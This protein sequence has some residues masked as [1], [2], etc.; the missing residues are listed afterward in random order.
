MNI[1]VLNDF[2]AGRAPNPV[3]FTV[4]QFHKM[5]D[6]GILVDGQPVELIDGVVMRKNR[7]AAGEQPMVH[8][9]RHAVAIVQIQN[10]LGRH[11]GQADCHLRPQLPLTLSEISEPE[12][13]LAI[14]AGDS[15][16]YLDHH[17]GPDE[18]LLVIE[19]ADSSLSYDRQTKYALYAASGIANYWIVN[20]I[21]D[22]IEV[23][24]EPDQRNQR[25]TRKA[26]HSRPDSVTLGLAADVHV[27]LSVDA[28]IPA[29][30]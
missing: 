15:G 5:L 17:P 23:Y 13:D 2:V 1:G 22:Q 9:R 21:D 24:T 30:P 12:P 8:G 10:L 29:R 6:E 19:V 28:L 27:A 25:Y 4:E 20:L 7:G 14:V 16:R 11:I 3:I 18:T 26:V